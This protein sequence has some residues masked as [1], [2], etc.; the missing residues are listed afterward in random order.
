MADLCCSD[1]SYPRL[2]QM[3]VEYD[4]PMKKLTEEFGPHTKVRHSLSTDKEVI[5]SS[6]K[7]HL[8]TTYVNQH[9]LDNFYFLL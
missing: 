4:H 1:P 2:G 6:L 9:A 3:L 7:Q 5:L 8:T